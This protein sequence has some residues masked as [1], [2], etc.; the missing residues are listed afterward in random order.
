MVWA[1]WHWS[2]SLLLLSCIS[3]PS[4]SLSGSSPQFCLFSS[5]LLCIS[6]LSKYDLM[7]SFFNL[8]GALACMLHLSVSSCS[9]CF[10]FS[11]SGIIQCILSLS[12]FASLSSTPSSNF[13]LF[14]FGPL[15]CASALCL[16][17]SFFSI[18]I[19]SS[20]FSSFFCIS[21]SAS[22]HS[23]SSFSPNFVTSLG[24]A[25]LLNSAL[26]FII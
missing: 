3:P 18:L 12:L 23:L 5:Q 4:I 16:F 8:F 11:C 19:F 14:D 2:L 7:S 10:L 9:G 21:T 1:G 20:T 15:L 25:H 22:L 17:L 6:F 26:L 24:I 13:I